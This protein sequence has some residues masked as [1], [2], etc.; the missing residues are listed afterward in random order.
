V[1]L[2]DASSLVGAAHA[3]AALPRYFLAPCCKP[4]RAV[5]PLAAFL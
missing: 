1:K 4:R 2:Y 3:V 5:R